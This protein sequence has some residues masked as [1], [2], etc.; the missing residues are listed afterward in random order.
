MF[1]VVPFINS[2]GLSIVAEADL[3]CGIFF[4]K[5]ICRYKLVVSTSFSYRLRNVSL[6][7]STKKYSDYFF[8]LLMRCGYADGSWE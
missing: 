2:T 5:N 6:V 4:P 8:G 1:I 7:S 3:L